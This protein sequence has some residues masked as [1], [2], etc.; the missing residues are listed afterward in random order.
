[1]RRV[2]VGSAVFAT[3]AA[4][5]SATTLT[6]TAGPVTARP[7][8]LATP[9]TP[10]RTMACPPAESLVPG[11]TWHDQTL[12][13]GVRLAVGE[14]HDSRG[15]VDLFV[16]RTNLTHDGVH[17]G[18][19][20][21]SLAERRTLTTLA[22]GHA[23]LVAATNT[24]Y[25]DFFSGDPT[26]P[27]VIAG[28]AVVVS[29]RRE[30]VVGVTTAGL[31]QAGSVWLTGS[32]STPHA[33]YPVTAVNELDPPAGL[34]I[35]TPKWGATAIPFP[36]AAARFV[37][38]AGHTTAIG[39]HAHVRKSGYLLVATTASARAALTAIG[40][41]TA[42]RLATAIETTATHPFAQ[43]YGVGSQLVAHAGQPIAG[44]GC[45]SSNT[46][47]PART[48]IG[49]ADGGRDLILAV[50]TDHPYTRLHGLDNTQMSE[51]MVQLGVS[52]AY[53]FDGSG[54]SEVLARLPGAAAVT[55]ITYP[56]DGA[57]RPMPLGLGIYASG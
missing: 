48:A 24:G 51:L 37:S 34:A 25:F 56:A 47:Q 45:K 13:P 20:V 35:Y 22:K 26:G 11:T 5:V 18:P 38:A 23:H 44:F 4:L 39:R 15:R 1:M 9:V 3:A 17:L 7:A 32:V 57:Q 12:A 55:R 16:I 31:A 10:A 6:A 8:R 21:K 50:V 29:T 14:A 53:D 33:T 36:H 41:R 28:R 2:A 42:V 49:F 52:Q 27:L 40:T 46:S 30:A 43:A 19:L 54:S